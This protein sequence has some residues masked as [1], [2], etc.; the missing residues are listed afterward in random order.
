MFLLAAAGFER[1]VSDT[2]AGVGVF[3][4]GQASQCCLADCTAANRTPAN[5]ILY[6][7]K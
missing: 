4:D 7:T 1:T 6:E 3:A 5:C 2:I